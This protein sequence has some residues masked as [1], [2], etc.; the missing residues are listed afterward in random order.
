LLVGGRADEQAALCPPELVD[1][2]PC[3]ETVQVLGELGG[4]GETVVEGDEPA[5]VEEEP[6]ALGERR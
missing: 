5:V 4:Y 2:A 3:H 6:P 1:V